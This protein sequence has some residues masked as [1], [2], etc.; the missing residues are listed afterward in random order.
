MHIC[1]TIA[2]YFLLLLGLNLGIDP[3]NVNLTLIL[4]IATSITP[5]A[6]SLWRLEA[7]NGFI[8]VLESSGTLRAELV[9]RQLI[10]CNS[11]ESIEGLKI[12]ECLNL[13]S[14]TTKLIAARHLPSLRIGSVWKNDNC[15]GLLVE[16]SL[17]VS[18][19]LTPSSSAFYSKH[20]PHSNTSTILT[21]AKRLAYDVGT[22]RYFITKDTSSSLTLVIPS[23]I[24][25]LSYYFITSEFVIPIIKNYASNDDYSHNFFQV[26]ELELS[27]GSIEKVL[28]ISKR[29]YDKH[30]NFIAE[31]ALLPYARHCL[32]NIYASILEQKFTRLAQQEPIYLNLHSTVHHEFLKPSDPIMPTCLPPFEGS[33]NLDVHGFYLN[34]NTFFVESINYCSKVVILPPYNVARMNRNNS[35]ESGEDG[36][37]S[38]PGYSPETLENEEEEIDLDD[39]KGANPK[40][41]KINVPVFNYPRTPPRGVF[42]KVKTTKISD[43]GEKVGYNNDE[44]TDSK[45]ASDTP[46]HDGLSQLSYEQQISDLTNIPGTSCQLIVASLNLV[47]QT[48]NI[49]FDFH[50][51]RFPSVL[52][53][54]KNNKKVR[55]DRAFLLSDSANDFRHYYVFTIRLPSNNYIYLLE[56]QILR[57]EESLTSPLALLYHQNGEQQETRSGLQPSLSSI[58]QNWIKK[59]TWFDDRLQF[60]I[61]KKYNVITERYIHNT[62]SPEVFANRLLLSINSS[63]LL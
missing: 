53:N 13:N 22:G 5:D 20:F 39:K 41:P 31:L 7:V 1:I 29:F 16:D 49:S 54:K 51:R 50:L 61:N 12:Q 8:N 62:E 33:T 36:D 6:N 60:M 38:F 32:D 15:L 52:K 21:G 58:V 45:T 19:E 25:L 17:E 4:S 47:K 63:G 24:F 46:S 26:K 48:L 14:Y 18:I 44:P 59:G 27:D 56:P 3:I 34:E 10:N 57:D 11:S 2:F 35:E 40:K 9:F 23:Y 37:E 55:Y 42:N 30:I 28:L 43:S